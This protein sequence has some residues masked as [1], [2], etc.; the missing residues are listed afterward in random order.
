MKDEFCLLDCKRMKALE[1]ELCDMNMKLDHLIELHRFTRCLYP[2]HE[3][4]EH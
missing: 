1:K 4:Y 2:P 3:D